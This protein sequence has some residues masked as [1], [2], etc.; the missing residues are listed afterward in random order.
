MKEIKGVLEI[1]DIQNGVQAPKSK[2]A[3]PTRFPIAR[4]L[5]PELQ[6]DPEH[7]SKKRKQ[8]LFSC[9]PAPEM[10][11]NYEQEKKTIAFH[12]FFQLVQRKRKQ[13]T[14]STST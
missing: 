3:T 4:I 1:E 9:Y 5:E 11:F 14:T 8:V 12:S 10:S 13:R 7:L 2:R 6:F